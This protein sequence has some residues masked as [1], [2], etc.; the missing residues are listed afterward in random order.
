MRRPCFALAGSSGQSLLEFALVTPLLVT[1]AL[2]VL[3]TGFA[4]FDQHVVTKMTREGSNLI[5]RDDG[6]A[7]C[8]VRDEG[9]EYEAGE[10]RYQLAADLLGYQAC[11]HY[12][13][14]QLR[15]DGSLPTL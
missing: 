6:S 15:Q 10:L 12:R 14:G 9:H 1:L 2:G 11:G 4:L 13:G 3:E 7:G 5:S 8:C